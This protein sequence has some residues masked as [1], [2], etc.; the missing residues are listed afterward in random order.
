MRTDWIAA[1]KHRRYRRSFGCSDLSPLAAAL[2]CAV[3]GA[4]LLAVCDAGGVERGA[5][6]LVP[7]ARQVL[8][9]A[10]THEHDRVLLQVV[11]LARNV[12]TDL[13]AVRQANAGDLAER[14]VRLWGSSSRR[15]CRRRASAGLRASAGVLVLAG[16]D[17]RPLRMS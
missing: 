1:T 9:A 17:L 5:D 15:A 8:D 3:L 14:R 10:A 6:H 13:E 16:L 4:T 2:L 12:G 11:A 7:E